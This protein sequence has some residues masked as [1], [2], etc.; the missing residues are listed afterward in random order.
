[1]ATAS[2]SMLSVFAAPS[3]GLGSRN[4]RNTNQVFSTRNPLVGVRCMAQ[5]LRNYSASY[6]TANLPYV[7]CLTFFLILT[8]RCVYPFLRTI[9]SRKN[10]LCLRPRPLHLRRRCIL[11]HHLAS[12]RYDLMIS[13]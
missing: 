13:H 10:L 11:L 5:V 2:F 12:L 7:T 3:S 1:M 8:I 4:I 6:Y 9:L